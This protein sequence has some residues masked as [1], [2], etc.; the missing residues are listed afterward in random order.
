MSCCFWLTL[1]QVEVKMTVEGHLD[2]DV[3][4]R[5][6]LVRGTLIDVSSWLAAAEI[7][8]KGINFAKIS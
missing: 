1:K 2:E 3:R 6:P 8:G 5:S 4:M 7:K